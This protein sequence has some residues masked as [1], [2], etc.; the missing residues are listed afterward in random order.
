MGGQQSVPREPHPALGP[1]PGTTAFGRATSFSSQGSF[2]DNSPWA[3]G[4][5][6]PQG[7]SARRASAQNPLFDGDDYVMGRRL[8]VSPLPKLHR[9]LANACKREAS[10]HVRP[11]V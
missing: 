3:G 9:F 1:L 11:P 10:V 5:S 7:E 4:T 6:P 2:A 8:G